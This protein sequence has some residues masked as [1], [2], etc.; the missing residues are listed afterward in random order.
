MRAPGPT[1][2]K[3]FKY[4][5]WVLVQ[6]DN[7]TLLS[8]TLLIMNSPEVYLCWGLSLFIKKIYLPLQH[9]YKT[10]TIK[11]RIYKEIL[12]RVFAGS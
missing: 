3:L 9:C 12:H 1:P 8:S 11:V 5:H 4:S 7:S 6:A 2:I 10:E